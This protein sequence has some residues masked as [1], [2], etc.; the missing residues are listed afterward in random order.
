MDT[1]FLAISIDPKKKKKEAEI[2]KIFRFGWTLFIVS[3]GMY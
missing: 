1:N 2:E 3:K